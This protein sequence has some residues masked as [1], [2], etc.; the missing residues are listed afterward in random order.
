MFR[1]IAVTIFAVT[2][3]FFLA[4]GLSIESPVADAAEKYKVSVGVS[5]D[6]ENTKTFIESHIKRELRS[7]QDVAIVGFE[8]ARYKI[9]I[10]AVELT[11]KATGRKSGAIAIGYNF[12]IK[13][14]LTDNAYYEPILG[15]QTSSTDELD[16]MCKSII[17]TFNIY[18]LEPAREVDRKFRNSLTK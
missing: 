15:V 13:H 8:D 7:L 11:Y 14:Y 5:V 12:L 10:V 18:I 1:K 2:I 3:F 16:T 9:D 17:T 4:F 6:D